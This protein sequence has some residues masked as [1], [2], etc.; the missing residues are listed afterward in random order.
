M[1]PGDGIGGGG[2][3]GARADARRQIHAREESRITFFVSTSFFLVVEKKEGSLLPLFSSVVI[4]SVSKSVV[5]LEKHED[6]DETVVNRNQR[7]K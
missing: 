1:G 3:E 5:S 2:L 6:P 4:I 7:K